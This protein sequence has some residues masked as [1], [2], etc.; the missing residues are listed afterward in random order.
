MAVHIPDWRAEPLCVERVE[1]A[2]FDDRQRFPAGGIEFDGALLMRNLHHEWRVLPALAAR[3][4]A[5]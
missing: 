5:A 2:F 3:K 1:S 4:E